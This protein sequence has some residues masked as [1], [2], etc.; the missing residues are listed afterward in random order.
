VP[1]GGERPEELT[2]R[3]APTVAGTGRDQGGDHVGGEERAR[4][5]AEFGEVGEGSVAVALGDEGGTGRGGEA[6]DVAE[7]EA[8]GDGG[9]VRRGSCVVRGRVG[10]EGSP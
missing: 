6:A 10:R 9:V 7:A 8:D 2:T 4:T 5:A 1:G 3:D